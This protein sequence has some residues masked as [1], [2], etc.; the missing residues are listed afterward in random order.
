VT[1]TPTCAKEAAGRSSIPPATNSKR[2]NRICIIS[3]L[4]PVLFARRGPT[5]A[6]V[7]NMH[8]C[9][10][11]AKRSDSGSTISSGAVAAF[12]CEHHRRLELVPR[13]GSRS[14]STPP[15]GLVSRI[16][17]DWVRARTSSIWE[18]GFRQGSSRLQIP[19]FGA[20]LALVPG[21]FSGA[22]CRQD[23]SGALGP[24]RA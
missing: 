3:F 9:W 6:L 2:M 20:N 13:F 15:R 7:R 18:L 12:Y 22:S 23:G 11:E 14:T 17:G 4:S 1:A 21:V 19:H 16:T 8:S 5:L 24:C 10:A